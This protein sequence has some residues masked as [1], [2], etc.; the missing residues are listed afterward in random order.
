M[1]RI[2]FRH[3]NGKRWDSYG[4]DYKLSAL[5]FYHAWNRCPKSGRVIDAT[6]AVGKGAHYLGV[7]L[8]SNHLMRS[9]IS[10]A[11]SCQNSAERGGSRNEGFPPVD[12]I[13]AIGPKLTFPGFC[14]PQSS[15][16]RAGIDAGRNSTTPA[17]AQNLDAEALSILQSE[18]ARR[19]RNLFS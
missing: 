3:R 19:K 5:P 16:I 13:N 11:A 4:W 15:F 1:A 7:E 9:A 18:L 17:V 14:L 10:P 6:W 2:F 12:R 8:T